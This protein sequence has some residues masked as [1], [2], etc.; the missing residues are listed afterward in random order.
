MLKRLHLDYQQLTMKISLYTPNILP[1]SAQID[2]M[3]NFLYE[4]LENYGDTPSAIR[5]CIDF[6]LDPKRGGNA[7]TL[8]IEN[9]LAGVVITNTTGMQEYIPENILVYIATHKE[10][11][12]RGLGKAL[13]EATIQ[14]CK[15][16]IA[17]HVEHDNPARFLYE[18]MGFT[19]PYLEMRLIRTSN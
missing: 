17:L 14:V 5:K 19:N 15:G 6:A 13:M 11:R 1:D 12:G 9:E 10:F 16:N 18:K 3:V 7:I 4:H 2:A 8:H